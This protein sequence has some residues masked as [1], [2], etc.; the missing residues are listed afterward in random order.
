VIHTVGPVYH[1]GSRG[2]ADLLRSCYSASLRIAT[3]R[4]LE[5]IA[6]PC[7]STGI[8]GYPKHDAC[9][10]ATDEVVAWLRE[11]EY[12]RRVTFC[13]FGSE[14]ANLYRGRLGEILKQD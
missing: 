3:E 11:H 14:D 13:C 1:N 8:Y 5:T 10:T 12:P 2:E 7:I 4:E 9:R 6:F